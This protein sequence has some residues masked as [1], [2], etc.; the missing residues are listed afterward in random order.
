M[1]EHTTSSGVS[2]LSCPKPFGVPGKNVPVIGGAVVVEDDTIGAV[3]V[4][5]LFSKKC[6]NEPGC[7]LG[8]CSVLS[9]FVPF[10]VGTLPTLSV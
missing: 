10:P 1:P 5:A 6:W 2:G 7:P 4:V 9:G 3:V 8:T